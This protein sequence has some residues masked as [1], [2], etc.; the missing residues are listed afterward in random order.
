[1]RPGCPAVYECPKGGENGIHH[2]KVDDKGIYK[3]CRCDLELSTEDS[4][5]MRKSAE[6]WDREM[7]KSRLSQ[8][9]GNK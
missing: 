5:D 4:Y 6:R 9:Q 7:A 2:W 8:T 3:C 1:M